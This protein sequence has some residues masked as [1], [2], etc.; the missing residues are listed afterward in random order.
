MPVTSELTRFR[1]PQEL[2]VQIDGGRP[3][4]LA[5]RRDKCRA[6]RIVEHRGQESTLYIAGGV[7]ELLGRGERNLN[8]S[9]VGIDGHQV[10]PKQYGSCRRIAPSVHHIPEWP[11]A[12]D[13]RHTLVAS[14]HAHSVVAAQRCIWMVEYA[15]RMGAG[16][17]AQ[18]GAGES[19][20][21]TFLFTDVEGS[22]RRWAADPEGMPGILAAHDR[23]LKTAVEDRGGSVFKHSGDGI[24]AVFASAGEAVTAAVEGQRKLELPVRIAVHT[25]EAI[26]RDDDFFG[27]A[28]SRCARLMEVAHGGQV[29][30]SASSALLTER[31][32]A[33]IELRD[34]GEHRLRDLGD[35]EHIFQV[36]APGLAHE[37]PRLGSLDAVRHNLPV[38]RSSFVGRE[39]EL[40]E[41]C[42][43]LIRGQLVTLTGIGGSGKTRLALEAAARMVEQF[44]QGVFFVDLAVLADPDLVGQSVANA[45]DLHLVDTS[46]ERLAGYLD[47]R[48]VLIVLDNC[49]HLLDAC[50]E[51]AEAL[52]GRCRD[53]HLLATSR[54]ALGVDGEEVFRVPSLSV[55]TDA[56]QLF[57]DRARAAGG[58]LDLDSASEEVVGEICRR[59]DGIPLP[60]EL[61]AAR[62]THLAPSQILERLSDR[63]RLLTGGRRRVQRQQTLSAVID[64]SHDLLSDG[65]QRLFRRLAVFRGSFSLH[66]V[67]EICDPDAVDLLGSLVEKSLVN[68]DRADAA[69][70]YRL[71]ETVRLYAEDRLLA[72]GDAEG[73]RCAHRDWLLGWLESFPVGHLLGLSTGDRLVLEADNLAAGLDWSLEQN[74]LDLVARM[75]SRMVGYWWSYVRIGEMGAWWRVLRERLTELPLDLQAQALLVGVQHATAIGD[76]EAM[77]K[78]S[79]D[80]LAIA[81]P[82]SWIAAYAWNIQALYW[83]HAEPER[84]RRCIEEGCKSAAAAKVPEFERMTMMQ[85]ANLLSADPARDDEL[86]ARELL[87][88][89]FAAI[90]ESPTGNAF[91]LMGIAAAFGDTAR[92]S[93]LMPTRSAEN[94][95]LRFQR[96]LVAV[97][98]AVRDGELDAASGHLRALVSVVRE[99]A[100]PLGEVSCLIGFAALAVSAGDYERASRH[101]AS[102]R[103]TAPFPFR[104]PVEVLVYRQTVA[105]VRSALDPDTAQRCR[106]KGA[107]I[108]V[109]R[110]VDAELAQLGTRVS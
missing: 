32:G 106:A 16:G 87:D 19:G 21:Y 27:I 107:T 77:Q 9:C 58:H 70:R 1:R 26:H 80:V 61:A 44:P 109:I 35:P 90:A 75:A 83:T 81:E 66:A 91:I 89:L 72:S 20:T 78:L 73:L 65:E 92:A 3:L 64:W 93:R 104:T 110:A 38:L 49:E 30:L 62:T 41:L 60:I 76:F 33:E 99:Y 94:P 12:D 79:S 59:L 11:L 95:I 29:L 71:L 63:F 10:P 51:L 23:V 84:G 85:A 57:T 14:L 48:R 82:D 100:I 47:R 101:L 74:R 108:P 67:E 88:R 98:I 56:V 52:L 8:G 96:E 24:C 31:L 36:V 54:E 43:R 34:L 50:A 86:G 103:S 97:V 4:A 18:V 5:E 25:G 7:E 17:P 105:A 15:R 68:I 13:S 55:E 45:L 42:E 37:F 102:I 53:L 2:N 22:T 39:I 46:S 69:R 28:L 40:I 6:E